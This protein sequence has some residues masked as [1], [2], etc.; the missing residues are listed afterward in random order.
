MDFIEPEWDRR[1]YAACPLV[2]EFAFSPRRECQALRGL[3]LARPRP[4]PWIGPMVP[5]MI[6]SP[7][8]PGPKGKADAIWDTDFDLKFKV[9][10]VP[11]DAP[12]LTP[13]G[14]Q[15][16]IADFVSRATEL[17]YLT[18]TQHQELAITQALMAANGM[19]GVNLDTLD[20]EKN[21]FDLSESD[22]DQTAYAVARTLPD[23]TVA[24]MPMDWARRMQRRIDQ[25]KFFWRLGPLHKAA[26]CDTKGDLGIA[27]AGPSR[28]PAF[29][30]T[31]KRRLKTVWLDRN[32]SL[33]SVG[34]VVNSRAYAGYYRRTVLALM[35][36][37]ELAEHTASKRFGTE[38]PDPGR[39]SYHAENPRTCRMVLDPDIS[40]AEIA[41]G[42]AG[43]LYVTDDLPGGIITPGYA[44]PLQSL[45]LDDDIE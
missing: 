8:R 39:V 30:L 32:P 31:M 37:A 1:H 12:L 45:G 17:Q 26:F 6:S 15:R 21:G 38:D 43:R 18:D 5:P 29:I 2:P 36:D 23:G 11:D 14:S 16:V 27:Y 4:Q 25:E 24:Y 7:R 13:K 9:T 41:D 40:D 28:D 20:P 44:G 3:A 34:E 22:T 35:S 33:P 19:P 10:P 42:W